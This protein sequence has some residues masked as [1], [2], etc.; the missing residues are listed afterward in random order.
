MSADIAVS[1]VLL[2]F[3]RV[4]QHTKR[5]LGLHYRSTIFHHVLDR[6]MHWYRHFW[7]IQVRPPFFVVKSLGQAPSS[8][9]Q[10]SLALLLFGRVK[11]RA[12]GGSRSINLS[13]IIAIFSSYR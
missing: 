13:I 2:L 6:S 1:L 7:H 10:V 8:D 9:V 12:K 3:R 5:G 11:H 4:K